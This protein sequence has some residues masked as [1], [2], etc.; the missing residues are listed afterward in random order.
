MKKEIVCF[1]LL[2]LTA[3]QTEVYRGLSQRDA[4][5]MV[6]ALVRGGVNAKRE[7]VDAN[8][9]RITVE[10]TQLATAVDILKRSGLP[11]ENYASLGEIFPGQGLVVSPYEQRVRMM[12]AQNQE[13]AKTI[14]SINGVV[15]ARVHV[16]IPDLD[17]RGVPMNKPSASVIVHHRAGLDVGELSSRIRMLVATGV[18]GL[19]FRDVTVAFFASDGTMAETPA[20]RGANLDGTAGLQN[21][22]LPGV[23]TA[24]DSASSITPPPPEAPGFFQTVFSNIL[25]TLAALMGLVGLFMVFKG[26]LRRRAT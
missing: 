7:Q 15:S 25:W 2:F 24:P 17:L 10:E 22:S 1:C 19:N 16:V 20:L 6:A 4:N 8:S 14:S 21:A 23:S 3:C 12:Y 11:K 9:Y 13:I 5:E 18:Q 26:R